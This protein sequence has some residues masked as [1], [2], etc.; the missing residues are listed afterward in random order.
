M[1]RLDLRSK[2]LLLFLVG[3]V[4][5]IVIF[6]VLARGHTEAAFFEREYDQ[7]DEAVSNV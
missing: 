6:G 2:I 5:P 4:L 3:A 1:I 7:L